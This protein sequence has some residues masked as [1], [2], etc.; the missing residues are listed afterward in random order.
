M[1]ITSYKKSLIGLLG[2][3]EQAS[4][5]D[6]GCGKGSFIELFITADKKPKSILAVDSDA[7]MITTIR[8]R[9][10]H[11]IEEGCILTQIAD[12]PADVDGK[13]DKIICHNVLECVDN[14]LAF[15]NA[16]KN[17]MTEKSV[18]V[19]SHHDFD[20]AIYNSAFKELTRN[21]VHHFSDTKQNWMKFSDGQ[22]GR[23][24]PGLINQSV[25]EN[26]AQ[27]QT[28]RL[29]DTIFEQGTYGYLMADMIMAIAQEKFDSVDLK[30]WHND[31]IKKSQR[32][33]FYFAIDLVVVISGSHLSRPQ[34]V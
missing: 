22:I 15:I 20:S 12:H 21:L 32:G 2:N 30:A 8:N 34:P 26:N 5:L 33:E 31:L 9:F 10:Q 3:C 17:K 13:F 11:S 7:N 16:F 18:F 24:I 4:I 23:R 29:V 27:I 19:L 28:W 25:F 6:Y 1:N 14:K